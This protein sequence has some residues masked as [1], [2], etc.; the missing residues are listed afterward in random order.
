MSLGF[1]GSWFPGIS[2]KVMSHHNNKFWVVFVR[3]VMS[4]E[5]LPSSL[6]LGLAPLCLPGTTLVIITS[7]SSL[8]QEMRLG[9]LED[10]VGMGEGGGWITITAGSSGNA[11]APACTLGC[12]W[13]PWGC[14]S[15]LRGEA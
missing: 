12:V 5:S 10:S 15:S 6:I 14:S 9:T 8:T 7:S 11:Q 2:A 1:P 3:F 13:D 4:L